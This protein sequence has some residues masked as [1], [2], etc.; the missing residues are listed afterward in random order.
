V[1]LDDAYK[2]GRLAYFVSKLLKI[3]RSAPP[4]E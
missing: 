4:P 2:L 1:R 3:F